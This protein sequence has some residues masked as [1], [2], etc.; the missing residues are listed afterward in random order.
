MA[1]REAI[2]PCLVP[3]NLRRTSR[4]AAVVGCVL[5]GINQGDVLAEGKATPLTGVKIG[6]NFVV[7][8]IVSNLGVLAATRTAG[9]SRRLP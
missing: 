7:P 6:L 8:F 4:I 1:L 2:A 9:E 5:T 3:P